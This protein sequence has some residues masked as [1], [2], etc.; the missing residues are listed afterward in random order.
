MK[1]DQFDSSMAYY[2]LQSN[3]LE[4]IY[5]QVVDELMKIEATE[6]AED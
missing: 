1:K 4:E 6:M 5:N 2:T 3:E